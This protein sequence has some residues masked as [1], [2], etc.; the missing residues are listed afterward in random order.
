MGLEEES[1]LLKLFHR[2]DWKY[3]KTGNPST[4]GPPD[5]SNAMLINA[6]EYVPPDTILNEFVN[7][8]TGV[9]LV[10]RAN[11]S[12][13][14][15]VVSDVNVAAI[16]GSTTRVHGEE[17]RFVFTRSGYIIWSSKKK[18]SERI[19]DR[20]RLPLDSS[21]KFRPLVYQI[22]LDKRMT[23]ASSD[24]DVLPEGDL[25]TVTSRVQTES[26]KETEMA[27]LEYVIENYS[28]NEVDWIVMDGPIHYPYHRF[29]VRMTELLKESLRKHIPVFGV[30]KRVQSK[31]L[32]KGLA[33]S[34]WYENDA[35]YFARKL[36]QSSRTIMWLERDSDLPEDL[37]RVF[38][39]AKFPN[40]PFV[41]RIETLY[42]WYSKLGEDFV[43]KVFA[44][45]VYNDGR[46]PYSQQEAHDWVAYSRFEKEDLAI[47]IQNKF[48][49]RGTVFYRSHDDM[50]IW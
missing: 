10:S 40:A 1:E 5:T 29:K 37:Q 47:F 34:Q 2:Y 39:F 8:E 22:L 31:T 45:S 16:D 21:G 42:G 15:D 26:L 30:T 18:R 35:A 9:P 50:I 14:T 25:T 48:G 24:Q 13:W 23:A 38:C 44:D 19:T 36:P 49:E 4:S 46:L 41:V 11:T 17:V 32:C 6:E 3:L 28:P 12:E 43:A 33:G 20:K 7:L 27:A